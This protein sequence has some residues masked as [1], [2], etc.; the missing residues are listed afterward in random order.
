MA[1]LGA[2][3]S[4]RGLSI[5]V[6]S[7]KFGR[8]ALGGAQKSV[9]KF[10]EVERHQSLRCLTVDRF[11]TPSLLVPLEIMIVNKTIGFSK[12]IFSAASAGYPFENKWRG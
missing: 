8:C 12:K 11:L 4:G 7:G 2:R 10:Q 9:R 5:S 3:H 6:T 1:G